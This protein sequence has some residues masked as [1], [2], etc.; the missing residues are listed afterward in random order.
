MPLLQTSH[1]FLNHK[2]YYYSVS[3]QMAS[4]NDIDF[5]QAQAKLADDKS[6]AKESEQKESGKLIDELV[7]KLKGNR[8]EESDEEKL[9]TLLKK[10]RRIL[11]KASS[12]IIF[13]LFPDEI[14][15]DENKVSIIIN[16]FI[17][18]NEVYSIPIPE[19]LDV[20]I[21]TTPFSA[22]L[23]VASKEFKDN[24]TI[25]KNLEPEDAIRARRIIQGLML[26]QDEKIDFSKIEDMDIVKKIEE[27]G[28]VKEGI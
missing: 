18:T 12:I 15:I 14:V 9:E 21:I 26:G 25:I 7:K 28:K 1:F 10:S 23:K 5:N 27:L 19:I 8:K 4:Q 20:D 24:P 17:E 16:H 2:S 11:F 13:D 22:S 6:K 3:S